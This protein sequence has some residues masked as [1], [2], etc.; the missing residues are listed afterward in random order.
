M[1][2]VGKN[3]SLLVVL[4]TAFFWGC[5]PSKKIIALEPSD[6]SSMMQNHQ[7]VFVADRMNPLRGAQKVL[8]DYYFLKVKHDTL[9]SFLPYYGRAFVAPVDPAKGGLR[10]TSANFTYEMNN[11]ENKK[12]EI[13]IIPKD[14]MEIQKLF[15]TVFDNGNATLNITSTNR[16]PISFFGHLEKAE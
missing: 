10:F 8:N 7:F 2:S 1:K 6:I 12:W 11:T 4:M 14:R 9:N 13:T 3:M 15:F 5:T 16:D